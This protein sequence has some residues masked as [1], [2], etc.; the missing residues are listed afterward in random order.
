MIMQQ[1]NNHKNKLLML[2]NNLINTQLVNEEIFINNE[3]KKESEFLNSLLNLKQNSLINQ[4]NNFN[5]MI[6]QN[7]L[8]M[9][10]QPNIIPINV[11][12]QQI[13]Q[14]NKNGFQNNCGENNRI[15]NVRFIQETGKKF[16][17]ICKSNEKISDIIKKYREKANDY[18]E[19]HFLCLQKPASQQN[20][21][22]FFNNT[23]EDLQ[24]PNNYI[25][26]NVIRHKIIMGGL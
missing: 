10:F 4:N 26:I 7:N 15:I 9:N 25:D 3:I 13:N 16:N 1:I 6:L 2:I 8:M 11:Q 24:I 12:E 18:N 20:L 5:D 21:K 22:I 19:N 17:I 23:L 14:N